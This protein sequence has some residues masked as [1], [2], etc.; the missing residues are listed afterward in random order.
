MTSVRKFFANRHVRIVLIIVIMSITFGL[1][2]YYL[3]HNPQTLEAVFSLSPLTLAILSVAYACTVISNAFVL[4]ASLKIINKPMKFTENIALTGYSSIVNFF[5]PLQSGPGFRAAY[6]KKQHNVSIKS[7]FYLTVLFY[8]VFALINS[9][10]IGV[11][12]LGTTN[13][14]FLVAIILF[15]LIMACIAWLFR[16]KLNPILKSLRR[17]HLN[18][19]YTWYIITGA[20]ALS[21]STSLAYF[22]ELTHIDSSITV[23]QSLIYTAAANLALFVAL[24]PGAIGF[25]ET[26]LLLTEKLHG[27]SPDTIIAASV[28]DRAFYVVFLLVLFVV[29]VTLGFKNRITTKD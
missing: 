4:W 15:L 12:I 23:W 3:M 21:L 22:I 14:Q 20:I 28:I 18:N 16:S 6:L 7:F 13:L 27:I 9:L 2:G 17:I 29:L 1:F 25:R 19:R 8:I 26:F 5:G 10:V 11:S 24:T